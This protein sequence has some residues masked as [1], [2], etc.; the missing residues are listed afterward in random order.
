MVRLAEPGTGIRSQEDVYAG[1]GR[2]QCGREYAT[3]GGDAASRSHRGV[4]RSVGL[5]V[6]FAEGRPVH[7][8]SGMATTHR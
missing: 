2:G 8:G 6:P 5:G 4:E 7:R 1:V 3:V